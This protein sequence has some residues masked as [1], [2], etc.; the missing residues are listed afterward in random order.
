MAPGLSRA[1]ATKSSFAVLCNTADLEQRIGAFTAEL[2]V[3]RARRGLVDVEGT[4]SFADGNIVFKGTTRLA[5]RGFAQAG[6]A[7]K[8]D[9]GADQRFR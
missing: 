8:H 3:F 1:P 7:Q 5:E 4:L 9:S 6:G 2:T